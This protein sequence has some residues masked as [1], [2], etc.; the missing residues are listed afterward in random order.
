MDGTEDGLVVREMGRLFKE[1]EMDKLRDLIVEDV[2][3]MVE[4]GFKWTF[5]HVYA[6]F[7]EFPKRGAMDEYKEG[8][9]DEGDEPISGA[10]P[11]KELEDDEVSEIS[12]T[13][14]FALVDAAMELDVIEDKDVVT[15]CS[16]GGEVEEVA[17][18]KAQT[19]ALVDSMLARAGSLKDN[20]VTQAL[21]KC[22]NNAQRA[23]VGAKQHDRAVAQ[24]VASLENARLERV[25]K[26]Q[27]FMR[28]ALEQQK[29]GEEAK[30]QGALMTETIRKRQ[31]LL[32]KAEEEAAHEKSSMSALKNFTLDMVGHGL[33][34]GGKT[35]H[36][37]ARLELLQRVF[38]KCPELDGFNRNNYD[39]FWDNW[40]RMY[41]GVKGDDGQLYGGLF[42]SH[43][44]EIL[45]LNAKNPD[46]L[47]K[48]MTQ[49]IKKIPG[50]ITGVS[51]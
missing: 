27:L 9:E 42:F 23:S 14:K 47:N 12:D 3:T 34:F 17:L 33:A 7:E 4:E 16:R 25:K 10:I 31:D 13:D 5:D 38:K 37:R 30:S 46:A 50:L 11:H 51:A 48:F 43:I 36:K 39:M 45:Q 32:R 20:A 22:K 44:T 24:A 41:R 2:C 40:E 15:A 8:Q 6:L 21:L 29:K 28:R 26:Q 19:L 18:E 49:N 1:L 35:Q